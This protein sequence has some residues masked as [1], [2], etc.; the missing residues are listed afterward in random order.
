VASLDSLE[1]NDYKKY[2]TYTGGRMISKITTADAR[3]N[4]ADIVNNVA[5]GKDTIVLTRRGK[6]LAALISIEDLKLLQRIEEDFDIEE[7]W[8]NKDEPGKN[9]KLSDLK[10][11]LGI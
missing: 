8:K 1:Y 4:F 5:Y 6:E 9:I 2:K 10:R 11:E 7:A 3:K